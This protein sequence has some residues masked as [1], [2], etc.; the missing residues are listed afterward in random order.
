MYRIIAIV[1][2]CMSFL[3]CSILKGESEQELLN[4]HP[5]QPRPVML[6]SPE[7]SIVESQGI[8]YVGMGYNEFI[9]FMKYQE[10]LARYI[11]QSMVTMCY[12]RR[13]LKEE[14]CVVEE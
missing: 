2:L 12:Y 1:V 3:S 4:N 9:D 8:F 7:W 13:D 10:D 11:K 14:G 5:T 6:Y